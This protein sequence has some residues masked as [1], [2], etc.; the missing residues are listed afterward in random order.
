M[1]AASSADILARFRDREGVGWVGNANGGGGG[2]GA[3]A[4]F[5]SLLEKI[6]KFFRD[7]SGRASTG[8]VLHHFSWVS[9]NDAVVFKQLLKRAAGFDK[10][11]KAWVLREEGGDARV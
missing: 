1:A 7:R 3:D 4:R 10:A 5:V 2:G 11:G 9:N 6:Q 8:A